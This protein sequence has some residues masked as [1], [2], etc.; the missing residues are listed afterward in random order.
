MTLNYWLTLAFTGF[1]HLNLSQ[2]PTTE[3]TNPTWSTSADVDFAGNTP[4]QF[5]RIGTG[6]R[7]VLPQ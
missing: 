7:Y 1:V 5:V 2:A 4:T 3:F 6:D